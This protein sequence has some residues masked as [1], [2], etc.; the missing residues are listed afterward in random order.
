[1]NTES[2]NKQAVDIFMELLDP[3]KDLIKSLRKKRER[4]NLTP[5]QTLKDI[6]RFKNSAGYETAVSRLKALI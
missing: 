1:M 4:L 5:E 2:K 3:P 6:V